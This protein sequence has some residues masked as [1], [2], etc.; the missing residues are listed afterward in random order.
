MRWPLMATGSTWRKYQ[1]FFYLKR[2]LTNDLMQVPC[3]R[4]DVCDV[5]LDSRCADLRLQIGT[6]IA[7][8]PF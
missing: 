2:G 5:R 8:L 4:K 1:H 7:S 6:P 3:P